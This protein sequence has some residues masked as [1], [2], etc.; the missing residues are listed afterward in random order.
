MGGGMN[1]TEWRKL[2]AEMYQIAGVMNAPCEVLD[3]LA[4]AANGEPLPHET[5]LPI[6]GEEVGC[7]PCSEC[8]RAMKQEEM[9]K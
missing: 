3:Q 7:F 1:R 4:A 5:L 8:H 2:A 9:W 6:N